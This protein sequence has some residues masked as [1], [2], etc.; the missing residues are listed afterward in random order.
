M[1]HAEDIQYKWF[2]RKLECLDEIIRDEI[3]IITQL[4]NKVDT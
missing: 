1:C 3:V 2:Q 4:L